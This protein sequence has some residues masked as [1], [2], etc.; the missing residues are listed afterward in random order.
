MDVL[1]RGLQNGNHAFEYKR[2][3]AKV[4][5]FLEKNAAFWTEFMAGKGEVELILNHEIHPR[6][7]EG[8]K[9]FELH[10]A[11][12]LLDYLS[13]RGIGLRVQGWFK[14]TKS[15]PSLRPRRRNSS[16]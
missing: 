12:I 3:L 1:L 5:L 11:P 13:T 4:V 10:L 8:D 14:A 7:E 16:R 9:C 6:R 15:S 2:A